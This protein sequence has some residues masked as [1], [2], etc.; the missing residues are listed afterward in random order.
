[1]MSHYKVKVVGLHYAANPT[2][3]KEM[4]KVPEMEENTIRVLKELDENR[5]QIV[6][7]PEPDNPCD[8]HA[9]MAR[10]NGK[11][12]GY[13]SKTDLETVHR[14]L[15]YA[16]KPLLIGSIEEV[17]VWS[18]GNLQIRVE[19]P[20]RLSVV[21]E[22]WGA[23]D[24]SNWQFDLP[25]L[26]VKDTWYACQEAEYMIEQYYF[27]FLNEKLLD[28]CERYL[29]V[30]LENSV[31]DVSD[32][33]YMFCCRHIACFGGHENPR[34]REWAERLRKHRTAFCGSKRFTKRM[35]WWN[36][37][38]QSVE[39]MM[40]WDKWRYHISYKTRRGLRELDSHLRL[41]PDGLYALIGD[42]D[43]LLA[44]LYYHRVPR[45]T[46]W[47]I[48]SALLLRIRT[49]K[50]LGIE[51]KPLPEDSV[52]YDETRGYASAGTPEIDVSPLPEVLCTPKATALLAK[53]HEVGM[54]DKQ[55]QPVGLSNSEK[56]ILA[57]F[58]AVQLNIP[59]HWKFFANLWKMN[60]ETLRVAFHKGMEQKKTLSFQEEL[61]E[62]SRQL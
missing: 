14:L 24:W 11:R 62:I 9:V 50:V 28:G 36:S 27:P 37:L 34:V 46:L 8:P 4:G 40:L 38:Q 7:I 56:G 60:C 43:R 3:V 13:V 2:Y 17:E 21:A 39:M 58:M 10:C 23:Y 55:G 12:I 45:N 33:T 44:S 35:E 6:L 61:K 18:R 53:L 59:H 22:S 30:W 54:L 47:S 41:L 19:A 49:C 16:V 29:E 1:M 42:L 5:P 52:E 15:Q 32:E 26:P 31:Y 25:L 51:M 57:D 48:Y 20:E